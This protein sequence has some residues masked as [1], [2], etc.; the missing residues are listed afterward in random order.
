MNF[1][2]TDETSWQAFLY[3]ADEL[4][5]RERE[6]FERQM[7]SDQAAREALAHAVQLSQEVWNIADEQQAD[8]SQGT[9]LVSTASERQRAG[10][11]RWRVAAVTSVCLLLGFGL[12]QF[13]VRQH[14]TSS[15]PT[16]T[17]LAGN[18][19]GQSGETSGEMAQALWLVWNSPELKTSAAEETLRAVDED[20]DGVGLE[21][22]LQPLDVEEAN[23]SSIESAESIS[24]PGWMLAAVT[25]D[26][27][28]ANAQP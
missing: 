27:A 9:F 3:L 11:S 14:G 21:A 1:Y 13:G 18:D 16:D 5:P 20:R 19:V 23:G 8:A 28:A 17:S 10:Q 2:S 7:E 22:G 12:W 26:R 25:L 4:Q 24:I 15:S 6:A